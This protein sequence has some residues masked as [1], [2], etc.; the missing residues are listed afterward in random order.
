MG[1]LIVALVAAVSAPASAKP[2]G[3]EDPG[4]VTL[5]GPATGEARKYAA[6][7]ARQE[8]LNA[9][10][11]TVQAAAG[12]PALSGFAGA[13]VDAATNTLT[14]Y[15]H[16]EQQPAVQAAIATA[17][18]AGIDVKVQAAAYSL[19]TLQKEAD[20][21]AGRRFSSGRVVLV[22][23]APDGN[24]L[25][26]GVTPDGGNARA[27]TDLHQV[28]DELA[29]NV[30]LDLS[31]ESPAEFTTRGADTTPYWGGALIVNG[32]ACT[33]GFGVR[34]N[35]G[36]ARYLLTAAHCGQGQWRTGAGTVI[37]NTLTNTTVEYDGMLILTDAGT[38]VYEGPSFATGD[39]NTGRHINAASTNQVG[40]LVCTG[41]S[42]SGTA[43]GWTVRALNQTL[44]PEGGPTIRGLV[45]AEAANR[46]AGVG[47]GDSGGP[48]YVQSGNAGTARGIISLRS[49]VREEIVACAGVP[50]GDINDPNSRQCSWKWWYVDI[51][52]QLSRLSV[53]FGP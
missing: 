48:V 53:H 52:Q 42:F 2:V 22:G 19:H 12:N 41:G 51:N 14:I 20:R 37:G 10:A 49:N 30:K 5:T 46:V 1:G 31:L 11:D 34:G 4:K 17:R 33:S 13:R 45:R 27:S 29:S 8:K 36:A 44:T 40:N 32:G 35:N 38:A 16:G 7:F 28:N 50:S 9:A 18:R 26:V 39:T 15:W 47:N 23:P 6:L 21:L 24:S 3:P 43:C 25:E